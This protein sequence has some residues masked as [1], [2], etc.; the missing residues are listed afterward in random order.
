MD[1]DSENTHSL[2]AHDPPRDPRFAWLCDDHTYDDRWMVGLVVL[3][4]TGDAWHHT[5]AVQPLLLCLLY[6][7]ALP[8]SINLRYRLNG[9]IRSAFEKRWPVSRSC[10]DQCALPHQI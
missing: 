5:E 1:S 7:L 4:T 6:S 3:L 9:A 2:S 8:R 10:S